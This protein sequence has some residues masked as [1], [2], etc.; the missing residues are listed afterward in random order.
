MLLSNIFTYSG[1]CLAIC[2]IPRTKAIYNMSDW[3]VLWN[4][5]SVRSPDFS[6]YSASVYTCIS[7]K[8][9]WARTDTALHTMSFPCSAYPACPLIRIRFLDISTFSM[10]RIHT[11]YTL[12]IRRCATFLLNHIL[13]TLRNALLR[14]L[15]HYF[16]VPL[17]YL[18]LIFQQLNLRA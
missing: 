5:S 18:Q 7:C 17:D 9:T 2:V 13:D 11:P 14:V 4:I 3:G 6:E 16:L 12:R 8:R 10:V 1:Y 15:H